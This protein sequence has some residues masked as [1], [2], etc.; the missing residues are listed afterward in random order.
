MVQ[1][2]P[3]R[4]SI[5][6]KSKLVPVEALDVFGE[7]CNEASF[8]FSAVISNTVEIVFSSLMNSLI[9][10]NVATAKPFSNGFTF[11]KNTSNSLRK[12]PCFVAR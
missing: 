11:S 2:I 3:K 6:K 10:F 7:L 9:I 8:F 5:T 4:R 1:K 12:S